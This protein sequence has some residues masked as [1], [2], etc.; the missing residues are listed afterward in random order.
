MK[1][2][3]MVCT[4]VLLVLAVSSPTQASPTITCWEWQEVREEGVTAV[5]VVNA[6]S[7]QAATYFVPGTVDDGDI[8][9]ADGGEYYRGYS[10]DWGWNHTFADAAALLPATID[11][12]NWATLEIKAFDVDLSEQDLIS[13]DGVSIGQLDDRDD[14]WKVTTFNLDATALSEL[15]DGTMD[16]SL[17]IGPKFSPYN[18]AL[19]VST[20][21][22]NYD[23]VELVKVAVPCPIPAP[24]PGAILLGS[25]GVGVVGWLRRRKSL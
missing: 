15:L 3:F 21:T 4:L 17:D 10:K 1:K 7:G 19:G 5:D 18:V 12:I 24:A 9:S 6:T 13:G 11:A 2:V 22:V 25:I 16:V 20:L 8:W 14:R 23:T